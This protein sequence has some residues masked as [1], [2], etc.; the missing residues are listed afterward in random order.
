[1]VRLKSNASER[2]SIIFSNSPLDI[3][4]DVDQRCNRLN[5]SVVPTEEKANGHGKAT[6]PADDAERQIPK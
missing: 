3:F 1:M 5:R 6:S 4:V 2:P